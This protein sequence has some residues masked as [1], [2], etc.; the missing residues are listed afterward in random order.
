MDSPFGKNVPGVSSTRVGCSNH[1]SLFK[2]PG[3]LCTFTRN[4]GLFIMPMRFQ[5]GR[6]GI[7]FWLSSHARAQISAEPAMASIGTW[8]DQKTQHHFRPYWFAGSKRWISAIRQLRPPFRVT[9]T[10]CTGRPAPLYAY[11]LTVVV[12]DPVP[13]EAAIFVECPGFQITHCKFRS[14]MRYKGSLQI[15]SLVA[16]S[17]LTMCGGK[18]RLS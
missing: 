9:S 4:Q 15:S 18:T 6:A 8:Q 2:W 7:G 3:T 14:S 10:R 12:A 5:V 16:T 17:L 13:L 1:I 11:P